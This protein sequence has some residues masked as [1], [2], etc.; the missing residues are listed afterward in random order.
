MLKQ[1]AADQHSAAMLKQAAADQHS[2]AMLKQAAADQHSAAMLKQ[3]AA[4]QHSFSYVKQLQNHHQ[5]QPNY[6]AQHQQEQPQPQFQMQHQHQHQ[7]HQHRRQHHHQTMSTSDLTSP[8]ELNSASSASA[9][10]MLGVNGFHN[11]RSSSG[12][13]SSDPFNI[14]SKPPLGLADLL[15]ANAQDIAPFTTP[16]HAR[17]S[18]S[19]SSNPHRC[20][21][22]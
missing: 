2:A 10:Q 12:S 9:Q 18:S 21:A 5:Q 1:A 22:R 13:S 6:Q 20:T 7:Q 8:H 3:A 16:L 14:L 17:S 11:A 15:P 4:D 19:S